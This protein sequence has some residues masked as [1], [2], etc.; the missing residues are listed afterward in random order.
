MHLVRQHI[1]MKTILTRNPK[2][3]VCNNY[4]IPQALSVVS[5]NAEKTSIHNTD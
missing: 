5:A 1:I 2:A 3:N 4:I